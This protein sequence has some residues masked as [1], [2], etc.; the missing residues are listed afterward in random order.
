MK[1]K[2]FWLPLALLLAACGS[3]HR[4]DGSAVY[5]QKAGLLALDF[6]PAPAPGSLQDKSDFAALLDWQARR[7][8]EQCAAAAKEGSAYFE[9]FFGDMKPFASPLPKESRRFLLRVREDASTA[10]TI[11]KDRN[12]RR[13][14]FLRDE[15]VQPCVKRPGGLAYP[16][17]HATL[18]RVFGLLMAEVSPFRKAEFLARADQ[19]AEYR[20]ISGVHHPSDIEAGKRLG[21]LLFRRFME[22]PEFRKQLAQ[23]GNFAA[24]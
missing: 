16:S 5:V 9:D 10:V 8:P 11:L 15:R 13:R 4:H 2:L 7:T 23:L 18:S 17:G 20:V 14:P 3:A 12:A 21:D 22:N 6:T 24:K 1:K 19:A